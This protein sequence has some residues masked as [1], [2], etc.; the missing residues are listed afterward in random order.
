MTPPNETAEP[1]IALRRRFLGAAFWLAGSDLLLT[2]FGMGVMLILARLLH[3]EDYGTV[4]MA[5]VFIGLV[6]QTNIVGLG[7]ALV[8]M[9]QVTPESEQLTFTYAVV[10]ALALYGIVCLLAPL[11]TMGFGIWALAL[12][13]LCS[14]LVQVAGMSLVRPWHIGLR[15]RGEGPDS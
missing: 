3:P 9:K 5:T 13:P 7:H 2:I 4:V 10:S 14:H 6:N 15:F 11:A 8:R 12:G 1:A